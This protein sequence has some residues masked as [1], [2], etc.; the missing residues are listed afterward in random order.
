MFYTGSHEVL[1]TNLSDN[2]EIYCKKNSIVI[3]GRN[4]RI[5]FLKM[6][7]YVNMLNDAVFFDYSQILKFQKVLSLTYSADEQHKNL[8][9]SESDNKII[10]IEATRI[11]KSYFDEIVLSKNDHGRIL[12]FLFFCRKFDMEN[13]IYPLILFS[14]ANT[15]CNK[16][17][18]LIELNIANKWSLRMLSEEFNMSEIAIRKRLE[19]EGVV[20]RELL[21]EIRMK[22]AISLLIEGER[23]ISQISEEIGYNNISYF[24]SYF[25]K[26]FGITPKQFQMLLLK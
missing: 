13:Q 1:L 3:V 6:A 21:M 11:M 7:S 2:S 9:T 4:V 12:S 15:F 20:F 8:L 14:A 10:S 16:V 22:K 25:K 23:T 5:S 19:S 24:I 26:F 18:N 17:I